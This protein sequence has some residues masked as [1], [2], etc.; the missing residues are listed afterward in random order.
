MNRPSTSEALEL[1]VIP[2]WSDDVDQEHYVG[3]YTSDR[4]QF[5]IQGSTER[6][7]ARGSVSSTQTHLFKDIPDISEDSVA[8]WAFDQ[9]Q[10]KG[11][12]DTWGVQSYDELRAYGKTDPGADQQTD[13]QYQNEATE[14]TT[15]A[16]AWGSNIPKRI[17]G[18]NC[19][20]PIRQGIR[21]LAPKICDNC[22]TTKGRWMWKPGTIYG[23]V[24][25][26]SKD[27]DYQDFEE[28]EDGNNGVENENEEETFKGLKRCPKWSKQEPSSLNG[29]EETNRDL[30]G[31]SVLTQPRKMPFGSLHCTGAFRPRIEAWM[32]Y[33]WNVVK[34]KREQIRARRGAVDPKGR[35][36]PF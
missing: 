19:A 7:K 4:S 26:P 6:K 31:I 18:L 21:S 24:R 1:G 14:E 23:A 11:V 29:K 17:K 36:H 12:T 25:T 9:L 15:E 5:P 8:Q 2:L 35:G 3:W 27:D 13:R 34:A 22:K 32:K 33:L 10:S 30:S 28:E 16:D 20:I